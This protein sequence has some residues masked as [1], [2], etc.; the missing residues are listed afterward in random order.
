MK[1]AVLGSPIAH[2][3]SPF[4]HRA[5]YEALGLDDWSYSLVECSSGGL[6]AFI[7]GLG[8]DWAGLSLTMP[9]KRTVMPLLHHVDPLAA[10]TGGANTV[11]FRAD[12]RHGYNTDVQGIIDALDEAGAPR[13]RSVTILGGGATACSALAAVSELGVAAVDVVVRDPSRAPDLTDAASRLGMR[14]QF[15]SFDQLS[16]AAPVDLLISTVPAGVADGYAAHVRSAGV[17]PAAVMDV[18]YHPWPTPLALAAAAAGSVVASGFAL[19]LHQ[20]AAQ[21]E[22]MTGKP[23]PLEAMRAAG[24]AELARR[25]GSLRALGV[26][27]LG[28][29]ALDQA[30]A[31]VVA[32][33]PQPGDHAGD[34]RD[35]PVLAELGLGLDAGDGELDADDG[36]QLPL[37][38]VTGRVVHRPPAGIVRLVLGGEAAN[39]RLGPR[40][41]VVHDQLAVHVG[42]HVVPRR[43]H[44]PMLGL[45]RV[46]GRGDVRVGAAH[47]HQRLAARGQLPLGV[48]ARQVA[49]QGA[50]VTVPARR[51]VGERQHGRHQALVRQRHQV[52]GPVPGQQLA[53]RRLVNSEVR[54][55]V[56]MS[57]SL[58]PARVARRPAWR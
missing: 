49:V 55:N 15:A 10:A 19:L 13:P 32:P 7:A 50:E 44:A 6:A 38:E 28:V 21:V 53:G 54:G 2:S 34:V 36:A 37:D 41:V 12:G 48:V 40:G 33:L 5:A 47:D 9:L 23:A 43:H 17:A 3:L 45:G 51:H 16:V 11:V 46:E 14:V 56:H 18:V 27:A 24:E 31:A 1:A 8:P 29:G 25:S 35:G 42:G 39:D 26:G 20:A 30:R 58:P 22:L 57:T 52:G 4:L